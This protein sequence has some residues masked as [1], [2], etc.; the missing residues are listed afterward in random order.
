MTAGQVLSVWPAST[1]FIPRGA[2]YVRVN[3]TVCSSLAVLIA[4]IAV[5]ADHL[6]DLGKASA[7]IL[8]CATVA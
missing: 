6:I 1:L 5:S 7:R 4:L 8:S 2:S 3:S